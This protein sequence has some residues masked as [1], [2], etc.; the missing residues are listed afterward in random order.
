MWISGNGRRGVAAPRATVVFTLLALVTLGA[1][2]PP[3]SPRP[4]ASVRPGRPPAPAARPAATPP[5]LTDTWF[6]GRA[7]AALDAIYEFDAARANREIAAIG[8]RYPGHPVYH[9]LAAQ[10]EWWW[11]LAD[12]EVTSRDAFFEG[13]LAK[14]TAAAEKR[15]RARPRDPDARYA[16]ATALAGRARLRSLRGEWV[17]AAKD[18]QRSLTVVR[19]LAGDQP[20]NPDLL[21]GLGLYDYFAAAAPKRYPVL[22][23]LAAFFP[24]GNTQRGLQRLAAASERGRLSRIEATYFLLQIRFHFETDYAASQQLVSRLRAEYPQNPVFHT[25]EGRV[26]ARFGQW[27]RAGATMREV[28]ARH[29]ARW[30][31]Y[32]PGQAEHARYVLARCAMEGNDFRTAL[33]QLAALEELARPRRSPY[34][35]LAHLRRGMSYDALGTRRAAV[36]QYRQVLALPDAGDSHDRARAYLRQPFTG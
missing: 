22:R 20:N 31:G 10:L 26:A 30:P 3:E 23:P 9:L 8:G 35:Q 28:L 5:V 4:Q 21:L 24:A 29:E 6:T 33:G 34:V 1:G 16:L 7:A 25:Y 27:E 18:A 15:L 2:R 14:A 13:Q 32:G 17:D 19:D 36:D 12:P 11:I